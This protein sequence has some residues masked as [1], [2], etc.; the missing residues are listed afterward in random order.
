MIRCDQGQAERGGGVHSN[1]W[2]L[3]MQVSKSSAGTQKQEQDQ[4]EREESGW[5]GRCEG[6]GDPWQRCL[7]VG[8]PESEISSWKHIAIARSGKEA[9]VLGPDG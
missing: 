9:R 6:L 1:S 3:T 4:S 5:A 8:P 7:G 2:F